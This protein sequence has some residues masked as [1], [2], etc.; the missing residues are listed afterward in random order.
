MKINVLLLPA[1]IVLLSL[2][3]ANADVVTDW[4]ATA[5][6]AIRIGKSSPPVASR[7]LAI[8]HTA[9]YDAVNGITRTHQS[10]FISDRAPASASIEAAAATAAHSVLLALYPD[11]QLSFAATYDASLA[12][13]R[14]G[15]QKRSGIAWGASVA[16]AI[17]Q[18][19]AEDGSTAT[20]P[21][22][23][24]TNPGD[25]V[26]TPPAFAP[27]L[28]P[29]WRYVTPF[30]MVNP[31]QFAPP[32]PPPLTSAQYALDVNLTQSLGSKRLAAHLRAD[33]RSPLFWADGGGTTTPPG[34]WNQIAQTIA[35]ARAN[36]VQQNARLFESR[37]ALW[38]D[39]FSPCGTHVLGDLVPDGPEEWW[40]S[41]P[42]CLAVRNEPVRPKLWVKFA[43]KFGWALVKGGGL[44]G[45]L[46][47]AKHSERSEGRSSPLREGRGRE[48][49]W[50]REPSHQGLVPGV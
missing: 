29:H 39:G 8:L 44:R 42:C 38:G 19:R 7:H 10:Y 11:Q 23:P 17:L 35:A 48:G 5:L 6:D 21:Y 41:P 20:L 46:G 26:P 16:Q 1:A 13:V 25:W 15:P 47:G 37:R 31:A 28:L 50:R 22:T 18:W 27:A 12:L 30:A 43:S 3:T 24:G 45:E 14:S 40:C 9:M 4:N 36:T 33:G 49:R 34:H 32:P 2:A